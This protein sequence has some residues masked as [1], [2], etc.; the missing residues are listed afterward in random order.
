MENQTFEC[1][2]EQTFQYQSTLPSLP[3]PPLS[4]SLEKYINAVKPFV[5]ETELRRTQEIVKNFQH[6]IGKELQRK[7]LERARTKRN[8]LEEWWLKSA[9]LEVRTPSQLFVNFGGAA[10]YI[11]HYWPAKEG[12]QLERIGIALWH[13]LQFWDLIRTE[14]L[15]VH[16]SENT[17]L[18]MDQFRMLYCTCKIPGITRDSIVS[19]FKTE[20][21]GKCPSHLVF[22]CRGR[23]F[24][25][26]AVHDKR[27][28]TAPELQRQLTYIRRRCDS[29][30]EGPGVAALTSE[31]RTHWA[32]VREYLINLDPKNLSV[33][34]KIQSS[35]L[36][37]SLDDASPYA[38]P[39]DY[40]QISL[41]ALSG[42]PTVRWGDKS[43]N[44]LCFSNGTFGSNC[45][46]APYDA[47]VLVA[48]C[49]YSDQQIKASEG[50]WKG[51]DVVRDIPW[52]EE[53]IFTLDEKLLDDIENAKQQY[54]EKA[55][56]LQL[57]SYAIT[58]IGKAYI[59][60]LRLHPDTF[61]QL[62]LQLAFFRLHGRPGCCYETAT[63]RRFYHGRTETMRPC[64][65]EV[66][67]FCMAM[68]DPAVDFGRRRRLMLSAFEKHNKLMNECQNGKGF[69]RHLLGL[70]LIAKEAGLPVPELYTDPAYTKSGGGG[71]FILSTS[72]VGYTAVHGGVVP[73]VP[74]GYGFFY[75]IR[76]DRIVVTCTAWKSCPET[77]AE[78]LYWHVVQSCQEMVQIMAAP[79]L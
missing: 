50:K 27:I 72:L 51:S 57:V 3:V 58:S 9:Y 75:R 4:E 34:E 37:V 64:T 31:E 63:T 65:V 10:P 2:E 61:V 68:L 71:N 53:L 69:D 55:S 78:Q 56:D 54:Y 24:T 17:P 21:E 32:K 62:A 66:V 77:D 39:E 73:M 67:E 33:L 70:F 48:M 60:K 52:P 23:I 43:Y 38:T 30:P 1:T 14:R 25:F 29:E 36:V 6:G 18:D 16:K 22:M 45:D 49:H 20:S 8:W 15:A 44:L 5:N 59:K 26:D 47:M 35:L 28:I 7:L 42:N 11:E 12:T 76:D 41:E 40:T 13:I 19:Y 46:H 74:H 79:R